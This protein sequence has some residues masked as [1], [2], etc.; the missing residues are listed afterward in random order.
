MPGCSSEKD[1]PARLQPPLPLP[2]AFQ[3]HVLAVEGEAA[4]IGDVR[5]IDRDENVVAG[6]RDRA[7]AGILEVVLK[8]ESQLISG[9]GCPSFGFGRGAVAIGPS[10]VETYLDRAS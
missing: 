7:D 1:E 2:C 4:L 6:T 8:L 10:G 3:S 5:R 9:N